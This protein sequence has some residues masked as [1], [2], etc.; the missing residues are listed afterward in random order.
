MTYEDLRDLNELNKHNSVAEGYRIGVAAVDMCLL[1]RQVI[2]G[3]K[4]R[5]STDLRVRTAELIDNIVTGNAYI[6]NLSEIKKCRGVNLILARY[7]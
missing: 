2:K 3:T 4:A 5:V 6:E 7:R 1:D